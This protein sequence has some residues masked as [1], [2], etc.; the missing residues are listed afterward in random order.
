MLRDLLPS[1]E[2]TARNFSLGLRAMV[3]RWAAFEHIP[4]GRDEAI[5]SFAP[6]FITGL[7]ANFLTMAGFR[8]LN[9]EAFARVY[10]N[11]AA[12]LIAAVP[13]GLYYTFVPAILFHLLFFRQITA[14]GPAETFL[15]AVTRYNWYNTAVS[16]PLAVVSGFAIAIEGATPAV[17]GGASGYMLATLP[18]M[19]AI[20]VFVAVAFIGFVVVIK[21]SLALTRLQALGTQL[22]VLASII[23]V[24]LI[25]ELF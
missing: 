14:D 15:T 18:V 5:R 16:I 22:L 1:A 4:A 7:I 9:P 8:F 2:T 20:M 17:A 6:V 3:G 23:P 21:R 25:Q 10:A 24:L 12:D 13:L 11:P 19:F